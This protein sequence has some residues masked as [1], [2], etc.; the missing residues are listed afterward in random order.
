M[1]RSAIQCDKNR[2]VTA[3]RS[4]KTCFVL[5]SPSL[6][7]KANTKSAFIIEFSRVGSSLLESFDTVGSKSYPCAC[8]YGWGGVY[9]DRE[10]KMAILITLFYTGVDKDIANM[11][12]PCMTLNLKYS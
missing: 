2:E 1:S 9:H 6:E 4:S 11:L 7:D 5:F 10:R 8:S 3:C 12:L